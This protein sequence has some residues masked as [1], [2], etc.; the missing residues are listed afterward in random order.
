MPPSQNAPPSHHA[1]ARRSAK[2][3]LPDLAAVLALND[4][5]LAG[6]EPGRRAHGVQRRVALDDGQSYRAELVVTRHRRQT[7]HDPAISLNL[8]AAP[9]QGV[10]GAVEVQEHQ[11]PGWPPKVVNASHGL[12]PAIAPLVQMHGRAQPVDL[13][14]DRALVGLKTQAGTPGGNA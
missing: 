11:A 13:V 14:S 6:A 5:L 7:A 9:G 4:L 3:P 2:R 8:D 12:L 1:H 10:A